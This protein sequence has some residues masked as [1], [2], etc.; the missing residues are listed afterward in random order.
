M[1]SKTSWFNK[2]L[3]LQ[4]IRTAGWIPIFYFFGL[5]FALPLDI[6]RRH[7][8]DIRVNFQP[9]PVE[10]LFH[11]NLQIQAGMLIVI[12]VLMA[13]FLFRYLHVKQAAEMMH[14]QPLRREK[15]FYH[16]T[17]SGIAGL[18]IP[19][20]LT[21]LTV[22]ILY[23]MIDLS[24]YFH[25]K[26]I[27]I[28]TGTTIA[29]NAVIFA[30]G[31][32]V[33]MMTGLS[34]IQA[35]LTYILLLFPSGIMVLFLTNL[36]TMWF[37]FPLEYYLNSNIDMMSPL[38]YI[39]LLD[40]RAINGKVI[41]A[42]AAASLI[43]YSLSLYF[44]KKR[45]IESATEA[46]AFP[47]LRSVFKYG[48]TF[49]FT[50]LGGTY[51]AAVSE[52]DRTGWLIFGYI[53]G[54]VIGYYISEMILQK[55]WRVFYRIKGLLIYAAAITIVLTGIQVLDIYE[56]RIPEQSE[57]KQVIFTDSPYVFTQNTVY[58]E[59]E[60]KPE[61]MQEQG[62][63]QAVRQLHQQIVEN[64]E[65]VQT[66]EYQYKEQAFF[67]YELKN[68]KKLIRQYSVD[69][70]KF[71]KY[72]AAFQQSDEYKRVTHRIFHLDESKIKHLTISTQGA[73]PDYVSVNN[74]EDIKELIRILQ[75]DVLAEDYEDSIYY[76]NYGASVE[77]FF[78]QENSV[79]VSLSPS[80][81]R[82]NQWLTE[83]D[84][85]ERISAKPE[86][87]ESIRIVKDGNQYLEMDSREIAADIESR[88]DALIVKDKQQIDELLP[89]ITG[90]MQ[91]PKYTAVITYKS[92]N[93]FDI[94]YMD[95]KH[96]PEF[97]KKNFR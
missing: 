4:A 72:F 8:D 26:D 5:I 59:F 64:K 85:L 79:F 38:T 23:S 19:V 45:K 1:P 6:Y 63:I 97:V 68:G 46:I 66:D 53:I 86:E 18:I 37:G 93:Q 42:Y 54:A 25:M 31:V 33:A 44:Y 60:Y 91:K 57:I 12:P 40:E 13:V 36:H 77:I 95:E 56:N 11:Y 55:T 84:L 22:L 75:E 81:K 96:A 39:A 24:A 27:F 94:V 83:K 58:D 29:L 73:V 78:N 61:P 89:R 32:L 15:I 3:I 28:W 82:V 71:A 90:W 16:F 70:E 21:S 92:R 7:S 47:K 30:A 14:S 62:N 52:S 48:M 10:S 80:Y 65:L 51:F 76:A 49:C 34:V 88:T 74:R 41:A 17:L 9:Q 35:V 2:Q 20:I 67:Y 43:L 87:V 50:M 69:R